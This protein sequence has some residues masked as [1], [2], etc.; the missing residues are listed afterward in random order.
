MKKTIQ[1]YHNNE[2]IGTRNTARDYKVAVLVRWNGGK[3]RIEACSTTMS[4]AESAV[5][6]ADKWYHHEAEFA[7]TTDLR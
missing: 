7:I 1:I 5:R 3:W 6:T 2:L 4:G